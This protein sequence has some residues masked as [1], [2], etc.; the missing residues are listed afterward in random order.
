MR[1]PWLSRLAVAAAAAGAL[2]LAAAAPAAAHTDP[3]PGFD[4]VLHA[5]HHNKLASYFQNGCDDVREASPELIKD[6][7]DVWVFNIPAGQFDT[8]DG[9]TTL[10]VSFQKP[11]GTQVVVEVPETTTYDYWIGNAKNMHLVAVAIPAGWKLLDGDANV[12]NTTSKFFVVTHT[13]PGKPGNGTKSPS[14]SPSPSKS[15]SESPSSS[16]PGSSSSTPGGGGALPIT[17]GPTA[18][19][20]MAGIVLLGSGVALMAVR[21]RRAVSELT[22]S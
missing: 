8:A 12:V 13:C 15:T 5:D 21:R 20:L 6:G 17:G 19:I 16:A 2:T 7:Y 14:P 1:S 10:R 3:L 9:V 18:A 22:E 11:D 4:V